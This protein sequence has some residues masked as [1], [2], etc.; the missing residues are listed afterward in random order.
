MYKDNFLYSVDVS[1]SPRLSL[2]NLDSL[3]CTQKSFQATYTL[4]WT[5]AKRLRVRFWNIWRVYTQTLSLLWRWEATGHYHFW[6]WSQQRRR[7]EHWVTPYT[8][9]S[10]I[11][12]LKYRIV[13]HPAQKN[14]VIS[15]SVNRGI[16]VWDSE[17]WSKETLVLKNSTKR[18]YRRADS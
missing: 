9:S 5:H 18:I 6:T 16:N 14:W 2:I 8:R 11:W 10:Y 7:K 4:A 3:T 12:I 17:S 13:L 1:I 15:M